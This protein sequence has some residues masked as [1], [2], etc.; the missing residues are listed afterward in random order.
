MYQIIKCPEHKIEVVGCGKTD[1]HYL[2]KCPRCNYKPEG[3]VREDL[4]QRYNAL[5]SSHEE[6]V[7]ACKALSR[8]IDLH[9]SSEHPKANMF[10]AECP[11]YH[12]QIKQALEKAEKLK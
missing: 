3:A 1:T 2:F 11:R 6:L 8:H 9:N 5:K 4:P 7:E 12:K 10:C